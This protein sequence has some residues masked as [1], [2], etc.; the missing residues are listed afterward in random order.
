MSLAKSS[1]RKQCVT[2]VTAPDGVICKGKARLDKVRPSAAVLQGRYA[3]EV[4]K[5]TG[6]AQ[7]HRTGL[8]ACLVR[9]Q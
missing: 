6:V 9:A 1:V 5:P 4:I 8:D 7:Q 2:V 3:G